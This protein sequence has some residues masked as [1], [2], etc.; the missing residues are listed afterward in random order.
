MLCLACTVP[1]VAQPG[2]DV[3]A[4]DITAKQVLDSI[5]KAKRALLKAQQ[6]DGSWK[7][8]GGNDQY[9]VGV[10]SLALSALISTGMTAE[11]AEI[12]RGLH[13]LRG[14]EPKYTYE[15]SLMIQALVAG[16]EGKK[17]AAL[18]ARLARDIEEAQI[19]QGKNIGSWSYSTTM[20]VG[21][22]DRSTA[23]FAIFGLYEAQEF[24]V[25]VDADTWRRA[26]DHWLASQSVNGSWIYSGPAE[27]AR[28]TGGMTV[29]GITTL[30]ITQMM[31]RACATDLP[32]EGNPESDFQ[33]RIDSSL[34]RASDWMGKN[35][36]VT[37][38]PGDGRWLLYY[39]SGLERAGRLSGRRFFV[40]DRGQVHDWYREAAA[41]LVSTQN[42]LTGT[43]QEGQADPVLGTTFA[44]SFLSKGLAPVLINKLQPG[45]GDPKQQAAAGSNWNLHPN[46]V[47]NLTRY[48]G[49][50]PKWP[51]LLNWQTVDI[52]QP[53]VDDLLQAPI[54]FI[55]GDAEL[56]FSPDD[57]ALLK[58][59]VERGG[60]VVADNSSRG[61]AFDERFRA[62][63]KQMYPAPA[64]Q[65][66][67]LPPEHAIYRSE[68]D[69]LDA[70]SKKPTAEL[71]A[72]TVR[73]RAAIIYL[74]QG[75]S[76]L[77]E[78]WTEYEVSGRTREITAEIDHAMRVG[79]NTAAYATGREFG[80]K[81]EPRE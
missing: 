50:R 81:L 58:G 72:V 28:G 71:F 47:R 79:A 64:A 68:F 10:A 15:I 67:Q 55:S 48:M 1:V 12:E 27:G 37:N 7:T 2:R 4:A 65:L 80:N 46:D 9:P 45:Q 20:R 14:Q 63:V 39:L 44:L 34:E 8:G 77:W 36:A 62:L 66:K 76:R 69:M 16:R 5:D 31:L 11:D 49:H 70:K 54:A 21:G 78:G 75:V 41:Y 53:G 13:W 26:Q 43:W 19:R 32:A 35:F 29:A 42:P 30:S 18:V 25:S 23:Q 51:R 61:P 24:G 40:S 33:A 6:R 60:F 3:S 38:N 57:A 73:G 59:Y 74:P 52:V 22:G 56:R 17:D